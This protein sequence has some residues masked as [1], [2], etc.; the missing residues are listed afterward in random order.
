[1]AKNYS[2]NKCVSSSLVILPGNV[3]VKRILAFSIAYKKIKEDKRYF[4]L[5][6]N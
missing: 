5:V 1:M 6:K 3:V 2:Q 4:E